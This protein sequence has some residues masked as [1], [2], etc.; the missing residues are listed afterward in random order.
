MTYKE[1]VNEHHKKVMKLV[2]AEQERCKNNPGLQGNQ[3]VAVEDKWLEEY[4]AALPIESITLLSGF[5]AGILIG[6]IFI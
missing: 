5:A 3:E 1:I 4:K 2:R 6:G